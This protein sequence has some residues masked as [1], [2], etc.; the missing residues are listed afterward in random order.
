M[1]DNQREERL[2]T[3]I[4]S[5]PEGKDKTGREHNMRIAVI[6][7]ASSGMGREFVKQ[8]GH[9]YQNLDEIWVIARRADRL[10]ELDTCSKIPLRIIAGD[11]LHQQVYKDLRRELTESQPD[12]RMLVN[13]AGFGKSG[14]VEE[15]LEEDWKSQLQMVDLNCMSLSRMTF[16]CLPYMRAGSRILNL[17]SAAAFC[18]QAGFAVYAATKSYVLS[19]SRGLGAE[20]KKRGIYVTA[21]CPG[22]VDTEFFEVSGAL[23]D[24]LKKLTLVQACDVVR[25]ALLDS[26]KRKSVSVYGISMKAARAGAKLLPHEMILRILSK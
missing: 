21:V 1:Q 15:I 24:P 23:E 8:V 9:F 2:Q 6:T 20:L 7:G 11:L 16:I 18:P 13:A 10:E 14:T 19:F 3:K 25:K 17:A 12:I 4:G 26:R 22:P 5:L